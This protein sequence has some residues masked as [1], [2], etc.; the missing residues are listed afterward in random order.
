MPI[1]LS[2]RRNVS[3]MMTNPGL[4]DPRADIAARLGVT[5]PPIFVDII[6]KYA[7]G[8]PVVAAHVVRVAQPDKTTYRVYWVSGASLVSLDYR[9]EKVEGADAAL[10]DGRVWSLASARVEIEAV[11]KSSGQMQAVERT[12]RLR[13]PGES[14]LV[15]LPDPLSLP[16]DNAA[17]LEQVDTFLD[18]LLRVLDGHPTAYAS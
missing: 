14:E 9:L 13:F 17:K 5:L 3:L 4:Y 18:E 8:L 10:A 11:V 1:A 15:Q 2:A 6:G 7:N 16:L 12:V